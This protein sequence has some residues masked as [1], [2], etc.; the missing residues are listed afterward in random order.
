MIIVEGADNVGKTTLVNQLREMDSQLKLVK[1]KHYRSDR[2]ETVGSSYI[3]ALLP[4]DGNFE[5]HGYSIADRMMASECIYGELFRGGCRMTLGQHLVIRRILDLYH[6]LI[7]FCDAPDNVIQQSWKQRDQ[8]YDNPIVVA[9]AYRQSIRNVFDNR[10]IINYD[11][12]K[13]N[14]EIIRHEIIDTHKR[15]QVKFLDSV[16]GNLN[17]QNHLTELMR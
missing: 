6:A 17:F 2:S 12:T 13:E 15:L 4:A 16:K 7:V 10:P 8:L 11:W 9:S 5:E 14:A 3:N 1:R